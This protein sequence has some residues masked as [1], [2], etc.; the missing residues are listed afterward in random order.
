MVIM[1]IMAIIIPGAV[2]LAVVSMRITRYFGVEKWQ[3]SLG[4]LGLA[5]ALYV[6][7]SLLIQH[8]IRKRAPELATDE[9]W[10]LTAGLGI[11]PKWV[12]FLGLL[13][14]SAVITA[15]LPLIGWLFR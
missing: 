8:F 6:V 13:S 2:I 15:V 4:L 14:I 7:N 9:T 10:E 11:V 3:V 5:F 1:A 12:S